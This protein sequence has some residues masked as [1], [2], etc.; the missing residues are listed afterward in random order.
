MEELKMIL[1][2]VSNLEEGAKLVFILYFAKEL[3][4]YTIGFSCLGGGLIGAYKIV[5]RYIPAFVFEERIRK[6]GGFG[7]WMSPRDREN[8]FD[9]LKKHYQH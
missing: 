9:I 2:T 4:I 6:I 5:K 1:Q 7:S 8:I 3:M